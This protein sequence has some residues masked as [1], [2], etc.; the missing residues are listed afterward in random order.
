MQGPY[1]PDERR[2]AGQLTAA[3]YL[4]G[5]ITIV[6]LLVMPGVEVH[7]PGVVVVLAAAAAL[8]SLAA[9][10]LVPWERV[11]PLVVHLSTALGLPITA[12]LMAETGGAT[13]PARFY[14]LFLVFYAA[15]FHRPREAAFYIALCIV[16]HG[17]PLLY[18]DG[19]VDSGFVAEMLVIALTYGVLG[20]LIASSKA[21]LV[22]EREDAQALSLSDSLTGLANRRA[23]E[24][25]LDRSVGG[26]RATDATGLLFVDLDDF[27]SANSLF[28]H[29]VGDRVLRRAAVAL[30]QAARGNDMVARMGGDEFAVVATGVDEEGM[31]RLADRVFESLAGADRELALPGFRLSASAGWA[32]SPPHAGTP[33]QLLEHADFALRTA[34]VSDKGSWRAALPE[35]ATE[36]APRSAAPNS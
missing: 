15:Y 4:M 31:R 33:A 2:L 9:A 13:S 1:V 21:R 27:K 16:V 25:L 22:R 20:G 35:S 5:A 7:D 26:Q 28:G 14:L 30:R 36:G 34:K 24:A 6:L 18:Q 10:T 12:I 8:W 32:V 23:L 17:L 11:R 29:P 19:S 3:L